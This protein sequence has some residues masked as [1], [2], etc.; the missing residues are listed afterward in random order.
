[1]GVC[2]GLELRALY[3]AMTLYYERM[4]KLICNS[5]TDGDDAGAT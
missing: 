1:M 3:A 4:R 2:Y 5:N